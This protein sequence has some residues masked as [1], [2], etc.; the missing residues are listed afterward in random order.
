MTHPAFPPLSCRECDL[1][2]R[3]EQIADQ[4]GD[5]WFAICACAMPWAFLPVRPRYEPENPLAEALGQADM[6]SGTSPPWIRVFQLTSGYPWWLPWR[7]VGRTGVWEVRRFERMLEP[8]R[9]ACPVKVRASR[10]RSR[11]VL[12]GLGR[13]MHATVLSSALLM[14]FSA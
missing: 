3:W 13:G 1:P 5:R 14:R 6:T 9:L 7:R 11:A 10:H 8:S 2:L 12:S 4:R